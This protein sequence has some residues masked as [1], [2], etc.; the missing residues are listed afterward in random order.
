MEGTPE[1]NY[2]KKQENPEIN[3]R[4]GSYKKGDIVTITFSGGVEEK[5]WILF[6]RRTDTGDVIVTRPPGDTRQ[7]MERE[8][9]Y[10][11]F[12]KAQKE[13]ASE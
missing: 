12:I 8:I 4:F 5:D 13:S 10:D 2:Q 9:P 3:F 6:G 7:I 1:N 11:E